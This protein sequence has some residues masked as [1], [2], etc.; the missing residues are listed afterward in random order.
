MSFQRQP[1]FARNPEVAVVIGVQTT[2]SGNPGVIDGYTVLNGDLVLMVAQTAAT[3]NRIY[4]VN[5]GGA[6]T[7]ATFIDGN[8]V[9]SATVYVVNGTTYG[10]QTY[11]C[12]NTGAAIVGTNN[13][14]WQRI[15]VL[16]D[17][18]PFDASDLFAYI[19]NE[20]IGTAVS[21]VTSQVGAAQ[22]LTAYASAVATPLSGEYVVKAPYGKS[23]LWFVSSYGLVGAS[24]G[25]AVPTSTYTL[26]YW[27]YPE[28][29]TSSGFSSDSLLHVSRTNTNSP[30]GVSGTNPGQFDMT[31]GT[32]ANSVAGTSQ[33]FYRNLTINS[34]KSGGVDNFVGSFTNR[35][36]LLVQRWNHVALVRQ[37]AAAFDTLIYINGMATGSFTSAAPIATAAGR[38]AINHIGTATGSFT[39]YGTEARYS[40][41]R[42][43][44]AARSGAFIKAQYQNGIAWCV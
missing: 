29:L 40:Q 22:T 10:G 13:L 42:L 8:N 1:V 30:T 33:D 5:T 38:W 39:V 12:V 21:T 35:G 44:N 4:I 18:Q 11:Q 23:G 41:V 27:I 25:V 15:Q 26:S 24:N 43:S 16:R 31:L 9:R 6:W 32:A 34:R 19:Y 36:Q 28:L 2:L 20:P 3:Q 17:D 7:A 14:T 37:S